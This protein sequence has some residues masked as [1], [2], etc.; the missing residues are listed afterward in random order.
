MSIAEIF[1]SGESKK[2]KGH[3]KNLVMLARVDGEVSEEEKELLTKI[4]LGIGLSDEQI[5][6]IKNNPSAYPINPPASKEERIERLISLIE[7]VAIDG[8]IEDAELNL[9][10]RYAIGL[11]FTEE[12]LKDVAP[13][14]AIGIRDG[15]DKEVILQEL[16]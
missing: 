1:E 6:E 5:E 13:K 9:L 7:M 14:I 11:G 8:L 3:F 16:V 10:E 4:G 2:N 15:K 12:T